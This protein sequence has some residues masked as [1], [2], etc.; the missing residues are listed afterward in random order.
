MTTR[1]SR[2]CCLVLAALIGCLVATSFAGEDREKK[3]AAPLKMT[4]TVHGEDVMTLEFSTEA[5][6]GTPQN[7]EI[8]GTA[9]GARWTV[10][11]DTVDKTPPTQTK[12]NPGKV[13]LRTGDNVTFRITGNTHGIAFPTQTAAEAMFNFAADGK[14]LGMSNAVPGYKWGT[15]DFGAGTL[16]KK[17]TVK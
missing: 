14:P 6:T 17:A 13:T 11:I 5:S 4:C 15:G 3:A 2:S 1:L 7:V 10:T 8:I 9:S 16:L 12:A